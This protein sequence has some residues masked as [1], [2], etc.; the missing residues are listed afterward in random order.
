MIDELNQTGPVT[1]EVFEADRTIS[2]LKAFMRKERFTEEEIEA[3]FTECKE[4]ND[5]QMN[6]VITVLKITPRA[7][8]EALMKCWQ[9]W[10]MWIKVKRLMKYH[11]RKCNHQLQPI[12]ADLMWAFDKWKRSDA[13]KAAHMDTFN[14]Q[15]NKDHN[16]R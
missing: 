1:E 14:F 15:Y 3:K 16:I 7:N 6:K 4:K 10:R 11:L 5:Y 9:H 8:R 12:K 2:N 13:E